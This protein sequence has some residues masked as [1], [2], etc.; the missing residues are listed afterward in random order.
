MNS[1]FIQ[2]QQLAQLRMQ[3]KKMVTLL[4]AAILLGIVLGDVAS[5]GIITS[6]AVSYW[7]DIMRNL[8]AIGI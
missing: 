1:E 3:K 8:A 4:I 7:H 6:T 2:E 5:D